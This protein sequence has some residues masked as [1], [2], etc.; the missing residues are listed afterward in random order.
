MASRVTEQSKSF[1]DISLKSD[2]INVTL[3]LRLKLFLPVSF[4]ALK[5]SFKSRLKSKCIDTTGLNHEKS[6]DYHDI[7]KDFIVMVYLHSCNLWHAFTSA[8]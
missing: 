4:L 5:Q 8:W 1:R 7:Y 2:C 3:S 6:Q